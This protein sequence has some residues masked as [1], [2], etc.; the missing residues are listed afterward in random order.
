MKCLFFPEPE[1]QPFDIYISLHTQKKSSATSN[2]VQLN[3]TSSERNQHCEQG[4]NLHRESPMDFNSNTLTTRASQQ[5]SWLVSCV[6]AK[7]CII[8][9]E[10]CVFSRRDLISTRAAFCIF[11]GKIPL[12]CHGE[13]PAYLKYNALT[14][15]P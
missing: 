4:L 3:D 14:T 12:L 13:S 6:L 10:V 9:F 11:V 8:Q 1:S 5:D 15:W 2:L 7:Y